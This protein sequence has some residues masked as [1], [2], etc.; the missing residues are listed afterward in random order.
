MSNKRYIEL[1]SGNRDRTRFP[2]M[3]YFEVELNRTTGNYCQP[4]G[5]LGLIALDPVGAGLPERTFFLNSHVNG[6]NQSLGPFPTTGPFPNSC[7]EPYYT[8]G[9]LLLSGGSGVIESGT[10]STANGIVFPPVIQ[11]CIPELLNTI[12]TY[13]NGYL[14]ENCIV[15][16]VFDPKSTSLPI[17]GSNEIRIINGFTS[18]SAT[19]TTTLPFSDGVTANYALYDPSV[20]LDDNI[21]YNPSNLPQIHIQFYDAYSRVA[22][23]RYAEYIGYYIYNHYTNEYRT[24]KDYD[25]LQRIIT[26][27]SSFGL[28]NNFNTNIG[29]L[30]LGL[31]PNPNGTYAPAFSIRKKLP[32]EYGHTLTLVP[33]TNNQFYT[34]SSAPNGSNVGNFIYILPRPDDPLLNT[35]STLNPVE[36]LSA[37]AFQIRDWTNGIITILGNINPSDYT[38]GSFTS[39]SRAYEVIQFTNDN[40]SSLNYSGSIVSQ[41]ETVCYEIELT[42]IILPNVLLT[43]GSRLAFYPYIFVEF[44]NITSPMNSSKNIIYSNNP[45]AVN[46]L[47]IC[48]INDTTNPLISSF[49]KIDSAGMTQTVKFKPN[50]SLRF[51]VYLP[52]GELFKPIQE[53]NQP[54]FPPNPYLQI[55]VV[56]SIKRL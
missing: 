33:G 39:L 2:D 22:S 42:S 20:Y 51:K 52:N 55:E 28:I 32:V 13:Y 37:Y 43:T 4:G 16:N 21:T 27:D 44:N 14:I 50:D 9:S 3:A 40:Y 10:V 41:N 1:Y 7:G 56:F 53:D 46:A 38:T 17:T 48:P 12:P 11:N 49:V 19:F 47:F 31:S 18:S 30:Y 15:N 35:V 36:K 8:N 34:T 23:D 24:I 25:P 29:S 5:S 26:Y 54:P 6:F 45:N